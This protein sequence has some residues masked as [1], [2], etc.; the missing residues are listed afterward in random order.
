MGCTPGLARLWWVGG[1]PGPWPHSRLQGVFCL[2]RGPRPWAQSSLHIGRRPFSFSLSPDPYLAESR[3]PVSGS[4]FVAEASPR[5][6]AH[7]PGHSGSAGSSPWFLCRHVTQEPRRVSTPLLSLGRGLP[8]G[9]RG[10][11]LPSPRAFSCLW[12][13]HLFRTPACQELGRALEQGRRQGRMVSALPRA[14]VLG[15]GAAVTQI[16]PKMWKK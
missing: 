15:G 11:R 9:V 7:L 3:S 5:P 2:F 13:L 8:P 10:C 12:H 6:Q 14:I 16:L 1:Q 4:L